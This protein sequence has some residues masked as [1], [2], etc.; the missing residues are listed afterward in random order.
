MNLH[1]LNL[2]LGIGSGTIF[3]GILI[4]FI[5]AQVNLKQIATKKILP[6]IS[7][8]TTDILSG[9]SNAGKTLFVWSDYACSG[10]ATLH[11]RLEKEILPALAGQVNVVYKDFPLPDNK[12]SREAA[13][14]ARCAGVQGRGVAAQNY[15]YSLQPDLS[16]S[17]ISSLPDHV[18]GLNAGAWNTCREDKFVGD[19]VDASSDLAVQYGLFS[20]PAV[21]YQGKPVPLNQITIE[22]V[23]ELLK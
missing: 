13:I 9:D 21:M 12:T 15:L 14:A 19:I 2:I 1:R 7:F 16:L 8:V 5:W 23:K 6:S 3:L 18:V 4:Y 22:G 11:E 17:K 10:C 20:L